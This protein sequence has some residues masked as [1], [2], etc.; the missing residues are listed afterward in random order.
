M[1]LL[2]NIDAYEFFFGKNRKYKK[3]NKKERL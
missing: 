1:G 2:G 3:S